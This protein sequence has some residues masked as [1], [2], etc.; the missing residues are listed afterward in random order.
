M[1]LG[2]ALGARTGEVLA[3]AGAGGKTTTGWRLLL[4]LVEAGS[5]VV[6]TTTTHIFE[7]RDAP[8]VLNPDPDATDIRAAL[9]VSPALF[10]AARRG[11]AGDPGQAAHSPYPAHPSKLVGL[12]PQVLDELARRLPGVTWVVEADGARG[13]LL[14]APAEHE[15]V[16]PDA[17][18]RVVVVAGLGAIGRP[19]DGRTV[20]RPEIA[21]G[22]LGLSLG[23]TITASHVAELVGHAR[24][25]LKGI[26]D[27]A[28]ALVLLAWW[29]GPPPAEAGAV[30]RPLLS[31]GRISRV[32]LADLRAADPVRQ[33]WD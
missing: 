15:P 27:Q 4:Q 18:G 30:A 6:F 14:K 28:E 17:A 13:L 21:A 22:L 8:C 26:P 25:G 20:H 7:P 23:A 2:T 33:V 1:D 32:I 29:G 16:I 24:G 31:G 3:V 11:E 19:L 10:L 9:R 12:E 5:P